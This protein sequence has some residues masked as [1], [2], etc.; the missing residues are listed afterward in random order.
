MA[1]ML[2]SLQ[3][4]LLNGDYCSVVRK[5]AAKVFVHLRRYGKSEVRFD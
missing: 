3:K 5:I 1:L 4:A 2:F